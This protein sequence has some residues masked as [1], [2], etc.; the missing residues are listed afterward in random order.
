M[1]PMVHASQV[2]WTAG[3]RATSGFCSTRLME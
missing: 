1:A 2:T 3:N